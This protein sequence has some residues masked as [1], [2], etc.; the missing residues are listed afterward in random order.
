MWNKLAAQLAGCAALLMSLKSPHAAAAAAAAGANAAPPTMPSQKGDLVVPTPFSQWRQQGY[1]LRDATPNVTEGGAFELVIAIATAAHA[2]W[3]NRVVVSSTFT[4]A[5]AAGGIVRSI[6]DAAGGWK[7]L[8]VDRSQASAGVWV[9]RAAANTYSL[10]RTYRWSSARLEVS[11]ALTPAAAHNTANTESGLHGSS[12]VIGIEL[13]HTAGVASGF[14]GDD[15]LVEEATVEEAVLGGPLMPFDCTNLPTLANWGQLGHGNPSVYMSVRE[16]TMNATVGVGLLARDDVF[17]LH[18][19]TRQRA[20]ERYSLPTPWQKRTR[21]A[22]RSLLI[23]FH[24]AELTCN[25][26]GSPYIL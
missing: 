24:V 20:L 12:G 26:W 23:L 6:G 25:G 7:G 22:N 5:A 1:S 10:Q 21:T 19:A 3:R 8:S 11:D 13:N 18:A 2:P 4:E 15:P 14:T 16:K 9:V 17:A